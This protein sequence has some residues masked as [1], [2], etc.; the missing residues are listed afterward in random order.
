MPTLKL[1][2]PRTMALETF[3]IANEHSQGFFS[4]KEHPYP[5]RYNNVT[6]YMPQVRTFY[7]FL[8]QLDYI[9]ICRALTEF[10]TF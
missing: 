10:L 5:F 9:V 2:R 3:R 4:I 7:C 1:R 6:A 8:E